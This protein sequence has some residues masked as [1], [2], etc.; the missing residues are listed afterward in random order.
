MTE[1]ATPKKEDTF[2]RSLE[3][4]KEAIA[5]IP[6]E[7]SVP[8]DTAD[9]LSLREEI[10]MSAGKRAIFRHKQLVRYLER[11]LAERKIEI[12][13]LRPFEVEYAKLKQTRKLHRWVL[14]VTGIALVVG[15]GLVSACQWN[16][17]PVGFAIGWS[18]IVLG[19]LIQIPLNLID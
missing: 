9:D 3:Q 14:S 1:D 6:E 13:R 5:A 4:A 18:L 11:D 10:Q 7:R 8:P 15:G 12:S 16:V 19:G 2:S 17:S